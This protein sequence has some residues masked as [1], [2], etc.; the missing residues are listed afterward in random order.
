MNYDNSQIQDHKDDTCH[1]D[2]HSRCKSDRL[3]K[4]TI[5]GTI[6]DTDT[7]IAYTAKNLKRKQ[8]FLSETTP[9]HSKKKQNQVKQNS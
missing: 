5:K 7:E 1:R 9:W 2:D 4:Q 6:L 3:D 8:D